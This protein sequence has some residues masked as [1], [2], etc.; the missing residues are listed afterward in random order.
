M[1]NTDCSIAPALSRLVWQGAG[2]AG[3]PRLTAG[4]LG[5]ASLA[6]WLASL[7]RQQEADRQQSL[8]LL[9][10]EPSGKKE[11]DPPPGEEGTGNIS[12]PHILQCTMSK[13]EPRYLLQ[14]LMG[15]QS[16][17]SHLIGYMYVCLVVQSCPTLCDPMNHSPP[18]SSVHADSPARIL[19]WVA[20][21][22]SRG[23]SQPRD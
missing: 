4:A 18:G 14:E 7:K 23:S 16:Q 13:E 8:L 5:F 2:P 22:S 6:E 11:I 20:M 3:Q 19:E 1:A 17:A 10:S 9:A 15:K 12:D 21:P